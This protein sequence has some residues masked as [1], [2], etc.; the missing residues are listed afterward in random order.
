MLGIVRRLQR[1]GV[2]VP[3]RQEGTRSSSQRGQITRRGGDGAEV[4]GTG[5]IGK[6]Y[7]VLEHD[8]GILLISEHEWHAGS[9]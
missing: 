7:E 5:V 6:A 8:V 1:S 4:Q 9:R 2:R 3:R